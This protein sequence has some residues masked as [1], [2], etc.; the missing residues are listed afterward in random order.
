MLLS[1][2]QCSGQCTPRKNDLAPNVKRAKVEKRCYRVM[3]KL[4]LKDDWSVL[5]NNQ[6]RSFLLKGFTPSLA[7]GT[8]EG[9]RQR[10]DEVLGLVG[11]VSLEWWCSWVA[12]EPAP[13]GSCTHRGA[14]QG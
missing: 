10:R 11:V 14:R 13:D 1:I 12:S 3:F 2:L 6:G 5:G 7:L 9:A 4:V 8:L